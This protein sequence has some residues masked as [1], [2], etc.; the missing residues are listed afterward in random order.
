MHTR[1][2]RRRVWFPVSFRFVSF[3]FVSRS[4][5]YHLPAASPAYSAETRKPQVPPCALPSTFNLLSTHLAL[6]S[7]N[8]SLCTQGG[9][10]GFLVSAVFVASF[11]QTSVPLAV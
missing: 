7:C 1:I 4:G 9:T 2:A 5:F 8:T 6:P 10:C 3:R 11:M